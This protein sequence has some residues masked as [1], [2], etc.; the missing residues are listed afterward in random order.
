[1]S[2]GRSHQSVSYA[3][4]AIDRFRNWPLKACRSDC[5]PGRALALPGLQIVHFHQ[6]DLAEVFLT[7]QLICRLTATLTGSGRVDIAQDSD[8]IQV[9]LD[10][11]GDLFLLES[12]VSLAIQASDPA[13]RQLRSAHADC[14][15]AKPVRTAGARLRSMRCSPRTSATSS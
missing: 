5:P 10:T 9:H 2:R 7:K 4:L 8:W 1:M 3:E 12:L 14:P 11:E 6:G 15:H 13:R